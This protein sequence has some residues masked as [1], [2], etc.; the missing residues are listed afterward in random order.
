M[1]K[2]FFFLTLVGIFSASANELAVQVPE[3]CI[4]RVSPC[5]VRTTDRPFKFKQGDLR[6]QVQKNTALKISSTDRENHFEI[7]NG[8]VSI[9]IDRKVSSTQKQL[10]LQG[11]VVGEPRVM[12]SRQQD[13]LK[14]LN[15]SNFYLSEYRII[16][17]TTEPQL[18]K[19]EMADK[20]TLIQFSRHHFED[21]KSFK[22]FLGFI[23]KD[24]RSAFKSY[25]E[26]QTKVLRRAV[27]SLQKQQE[28]E[29][30]RNFR[31]SRKTKKVRDDFFSRT[32][33]R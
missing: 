17:R 10:S 19:T 21:L 4:N 14:I 3:N 27:A 29:A 22:L 16:N 5:L 32:F 20:K 2:E 11:V 26:N 15:M 25:S 30:E 13:E 33:E 23:E 31:N 7:L 28:L 8:R 18:I 1:T 9:N 24:W 6:V 12:V